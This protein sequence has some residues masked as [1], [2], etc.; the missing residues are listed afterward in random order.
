VTQHYKGVT[1][2]ARTQLVDVCVQVLKQCAAAS[3]LFT[4]DVPTTAWLDLR[5]F[6]VKT[7]TGMGP[8]HA[9]KLI[10][11]LV[12]AKWAPMVQDGEPVDILGPGC[13]TGIMVREPCVMIRV[14]V[15][16]V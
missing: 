7:F 1:R 10:I 4:G 8:F 16:T 9:D 2:R 14:H 11:G 13:C 5:T 6:F 15:H 3:E 12:L